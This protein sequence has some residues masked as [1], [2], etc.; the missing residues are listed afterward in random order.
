MPG[1]ISRSRRSGA[2]NRTKS[3]SGLGCVMSADVVGCRVCGGPP[4]GL[5]DQ[6]G[7]A[8]KPGQGG[9]DKCPI[10]GSRLPPGRTYREDA[11][12]PPRGLA[13]LWDRTW[14]LGCRPGP[15]AHPYHPGEDDPLA[16]PAASRSRRRDERGDIGDPRAARTVS[17]RFD[18]ERRHP[19][20]AASGRPRRSS[21]PHPRS[22][23]GFPD[24]DTA[25][26][27]WRPGANRSACLRGSRAA[28]A[29]RARGQII[30]RRRGRD[31]GRRRRRGADGFRRGGLL[32]RGG[33]VAAA[34][35]LSGPVSS[36]RG[37]RRGRDRRDHVPCLL[38]RLTRARLESGDRGR[39]RR[40][41][42]LGMGSLA[43]GHGDDEEHDRRGDRQTKAR[44]RGQESPADTR[45]PSRR[46]RLASTHP[47]VEPSPAQASLRGS[48]HGRCPQDRSRRSMAVRTIWGQSA[49]PS[50]RQ[51]ERDRSAWWSRIRRSSMG[52]TEG[53][54]GPGAGCGRQGPGSPSF[55]R[56]WP[57]VRGKGAVLEVPLDPARSAG[58][59][60]PLVGET[61]IVS[62]QERKPLMHP[63][64]G[65]TS[66]DRASAILSHPWPPVAPVL[67]AMPDLAELLAGLG[68]PPANG[69]LLPADDCRD[70]RG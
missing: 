69:R 17:G 20:A 23:P 9:P 19:R 1:A 8:R 14:R 22:R 16:K 47:V 53:V 59:R 44:G 42:D 29:Y 64:A 62:H 45:E 18:R 31:H 34:A 21:S 12:L 35:G 2:A 33:S 11:H 52:Q 66:H 24:L 3:S 15:V 26:G 38:P 28:W 46:A 4:G 49:R 67:P 40:D 63:C 41:L 54:S 39:I 55:A 25:V 32:R 51:R 43:A 68:E 57:V 48:S 37:S 5:T 6:T 56:A 60:S 50:R 61:L 58:S 70:L 10:E 27:L 36:R 7:W 30:A 65:R 13:C